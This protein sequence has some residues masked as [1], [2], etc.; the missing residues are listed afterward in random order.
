MKM[1]KS[2]K[3]DKISWQSIIIMLL[4]YN[5]IS[6]CAIEWTSWVIYGESE[7]NKWRF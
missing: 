1:V 7:S 4:A 3:I 2:G 6:E 5:G